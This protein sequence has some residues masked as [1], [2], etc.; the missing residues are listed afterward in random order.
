MERKIEIKWSE[1]TIEMKKRSQREF[2]EIY[3]EE[4]RE[5]VIRMLTKLMR[6]IPVREPREE[7]NNLEKLC[8]NAQINICR[9]A[10]MNHG[11]NETHG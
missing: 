2:K 5:E 4:D 9:I 11:E 3:E 7:A 1:E 6:K 8:E 10:Q